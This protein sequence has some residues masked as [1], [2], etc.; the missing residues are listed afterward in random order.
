MGRDVSSYGFEDRPRR[1]VRKPEEK[2]ASAMSGDSVAAP[3]M[4]AGSLE[5]S[6]LLQTVISRDV[7]KAIRDSF[8]TKNPKA[9]DKAVDAVSRAVLYE[10]TAVKN[11]P[12]EQMQEVLNKHVNAYLET[13]GVKAPEAFKPVDGE[14]EELPDSAVEELPEEIPAPAESAQE[15]KTAK[16]AAFMV[17]EKMSVGKS[18]QEVADE[19]HAQ[20][21]A[22]NAELNKSLSE[23]PKDPVKAM[24]REA[25]I[26]DRTRMLDVVHA[27]IAVAESLAQKQEAA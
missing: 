25:I 7:K 21:D 12:K 4:E 24:R 20:L 8:D 9:L 11:M 14:P 5:R 27:Q 2:A 13:R 22:L 1:V 6:T 15:R 26:E 16:L 3:R 19:L 17:K 18:A 23:S 10:V